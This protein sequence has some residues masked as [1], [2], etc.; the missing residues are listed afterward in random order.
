VGEALLTTPLL[1]AL[2]S[3]GSPERSPERVMQ[4]D[5]LVHQKVA[6]VLEGHPAAHRV[7]PFDRRRLWLGP[8]APGIRA[9]R[10][11]RYDVVVDC[12]NWTAP[13]VTSALV[14]RL[15]A[16][17][18]L[19][20]GPALWPVR[21]LHD[22]AVPA[23]AG[24]RSEA[25]QRLHLLSALPGL[26]TPAAAAPRLSFR[27]P[28]LREG[29][30]AAALLAQLHGRPYA[31]VN[32]GGRMGWRRVDPRVFA[33]GARAL[34]AH[35]VLPVV[36]WGPGEE[37]VAAAVLAGAPG[38]QLAPPTDLDELAALMAGARLTLCNNT[39]PMHLSV[40]VGTPTLA[41]FL[42]MELERWG[43]PQ[44]PHRMLDLTP[45]PAASHEDAVARAVGAMLGTQGDAQQ[46]AVGVGSSRGE[47]R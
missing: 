4:V 45:L 27:A 1:E 5:L 33:A 42:H 38:A 44:A 41:L 39:G 2:R 46:R 13:S 10:R 43:H 9:L 47:A 16:P 31:V 32:P 25:A 35:G 6:R 30:S 26:A 11:E 28:R 7:R 37:A 23:R 12:A 17:R 22:V 8:L 3:A 24:T 18:A 15:V 20:L 21:L 36:T 14:S 34:A 40:A 19:L 29:S